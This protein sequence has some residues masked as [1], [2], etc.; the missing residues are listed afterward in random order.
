MHLVMQDSRAHIAAV[1]CCQVSE[2]SALT[3]RLWLQPRNRW[4][5]DQ[6]KRFCMLTHTFRMGMVCGAGTAIPCGG[7]EPLEGG[8]PMGGFAFTSGSDPF[9]NWSYVEDVL[10]YNWSVPVLGGGTETMRR[11]E[12]PFLLFDDYGKVYLFTAVSPANTSV[13]MYTHV[14]EV[15][16]PPG[17][18]GPPHFEAVRWL[19]PNHVLDRDIEQSVR[20]SK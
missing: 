17:V 1:P 19:Q 3:K 16:L 7:G 9:A 20:L 13:Q 6:R 10:A 11:R 15:L 5:D 4:W 2:S 12:R 8:E 14:Q 18:G